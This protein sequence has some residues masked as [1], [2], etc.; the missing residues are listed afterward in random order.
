[1]GLV[2]LFLALVLILWVFSG[3]WIIWFC[4]LLYKAWCGGW[5][6]CGWG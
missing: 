1:M 3:G 6:C 5:V 4:R 2:I